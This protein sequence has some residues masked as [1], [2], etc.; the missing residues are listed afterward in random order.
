MNMKQK[1]TAARAGSKKS[2]TWKAQWFWGFR[3]EGLGG[4]GFRVL[5]LRFRVHG[6]NGKERKNYTGLY[7]DYKGGLG[8]KI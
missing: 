5:G 2:S 1:I 4:L 7:R 8:F 3:V 6:D